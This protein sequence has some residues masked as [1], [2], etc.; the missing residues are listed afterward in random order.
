MTWQQC[1]RL[2]FNRLKHAVNG[3]AGWTAARLLADWGTSLARFVK[4]MPDDYRRA[5]EEAAAQVDG[6]MRG[7]APCAAPW[8]SRPWHS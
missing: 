1:R 5:I 4:V 3:V 6:P 8:P 7:P 2:M